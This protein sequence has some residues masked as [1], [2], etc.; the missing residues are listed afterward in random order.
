MKFIKEE[1]YQACQYYQSAGVSVTKA[2]KK[3][4]IDRHTLTKYLS[5]NF[6]DCIYSPEEH[7]YIQFTPK[8]QQALQEYQDGTIENARAIKCKF[9]FHHDKFHQMCQYAGVQEHND[10]RKYHFNRNAFR[11]IN[12]EEG[13]YILGFI[14]ADGYL[15]ESRAELRIKIHARDIDILHKINQYLQSNIPI[16]YER[17][18]L[19]GHLLC[20][21]S[22]C[23]ASIVQHLKQYG[24]HQAK[25]LKE[26]FYHDIHPTLIRHYI[27]G[28]IDGDG[29][30]SQKT[31]HLGLCGSKN[32]VTNVAM[33]LAQHMTN[34]YDVQQKVRQENH[35][36][37]YRFELSGQ[38]ARDAMRWLYAGSHIH[39]DR[40]YNLVQQ[41]INLK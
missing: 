8:E 5:F 6:D 3:F 18:N 19:T 16:H 7:L 12:T 11:E 25:S 10:L 39:L 4:N 22:I 40:K 36:Q 2:A 27:R 26:T 14:T 31:C 29:F 21:L 38:N 24:I 30:I 9:G 13:A 28:L 32:V 33:Q 15:C 41:Y 35:S 23:S 20:K 37:L 1:I 17:H 34:P